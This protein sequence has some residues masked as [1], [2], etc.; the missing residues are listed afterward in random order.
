M[1]RNAIKGRGFTYPGD[2]RVFVVKEARKHSVTFVC[3]HWCTDNVFK[4][5]IPVSNNNQLNLFQRFLPCKTGLA[6]S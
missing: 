5:L 1:K 4:D 2:D 6:Q 3:G